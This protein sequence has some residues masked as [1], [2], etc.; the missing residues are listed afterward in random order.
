[1]EMQTANGQNTVQNGKK[2]LK[3]SNQNGTIK[4]P[5]YG[6]LLY[7][8]DEKFGRTAVLHELHT[9]AF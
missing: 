6:T 7:E 4:T 5:Q 1:M 2:I 3:K 9:V 8:Q